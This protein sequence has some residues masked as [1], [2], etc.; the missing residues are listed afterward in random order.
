M[1]DAKGCRDCGQLVRWTPYEVN[2]RGE[3]L[4]G[5]DGKV[6]VHK[7]ERRGDAA[8]PQSGDAGQLMVMPFGKYRGWKVSKLAETA[9]GIDYLKWAGE[10][11]T[12]QWLKDAIDQVLKGEYGSNLRPAGSSSESPSGGDSWDD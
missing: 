1:A 7:C 3:F 9:E 4:R 8:G 6:I 10:H 11:A 12:K 5:P 2:P